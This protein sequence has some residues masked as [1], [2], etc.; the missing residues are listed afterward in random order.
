[1]EVHDMNIESITISRSISG[2]LKFLLNWV[3]LP[4]AET[5]ARFVNCWE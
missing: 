3:N 2:L 4:D 5:L 1:M